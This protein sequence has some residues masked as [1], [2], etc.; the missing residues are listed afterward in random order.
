MVMDLKEEMASIYEAQDPWNYGKA[1][2]H[3]VTVG[4]C[5]QHW[6]GGTL[7]E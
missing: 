2:R 3:M 6:G 7:V 1:N 5:Q 4:V